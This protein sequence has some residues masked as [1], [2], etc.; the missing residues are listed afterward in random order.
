MLFHWPNRDD[1]S[2]LAFLSCIISQL[3]Y[4]F[5]VGVSVMFFFIGRKCDDGFKLVFLPCFIIGQNWDDCS[6]LV[7]LPCFIIVI[8]AKTVLRWCSSHVLH[9]DNF[10]KLV[11]LSCFFHW[12]KL[13]VLF[14]FGVSV[15]F[16]H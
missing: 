14:Q 4:F 6:K 2:K 3:R 9:C 11:F 7:F 1:C 13:R 10:S 12:P 5:Q 8:V 16:Y 15:K